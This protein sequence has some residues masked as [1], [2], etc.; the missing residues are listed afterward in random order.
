MTYVKLLMHSTHH[1][2]IFSCTLIWMA[3]LPFHINSLFKQ[4]KTS[5]SFFQGENYAPQAFNIL[6]WFDLVLLYKG[7]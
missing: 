7:T 2:T 3:L 5:I 1:F 4:P 6:V